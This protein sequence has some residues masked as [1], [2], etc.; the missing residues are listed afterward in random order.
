M[1]DKQENHH[2]ISCW[3]APFK[4]QAFQ[5]AGWSNQRFENYKGSYTWKLQ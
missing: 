3:H 2:S 4:K 1:V 5:N